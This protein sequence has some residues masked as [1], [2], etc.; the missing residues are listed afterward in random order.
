M[1]IIRVFDTKNQK[2]MKPLADNQVDRNKVTSISITHDGAYLLA[3][4]KK[5]TLVLW[6]LAKYK[7]MIVISNV[8]EGEITAA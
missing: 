7:L 4:Y 3:G 6:D 2:E 5:G 1:G 8:H